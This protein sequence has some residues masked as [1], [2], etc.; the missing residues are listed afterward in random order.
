M[1]WHNEDGLYI[2]FGREEGTSTHSGGSYCYGD[3]G[4]QTAELTLDLTTL[5]E[6]ESVQ[7]DVLII[8]DNALIAEVTVETLVAAATGTGIDVGTIHISRDTSD[9]EWTADPDGLL[10]AFVAAT[11]SVVGERVTFYGPTSANT[12]ESLPASITTGGVQIGDVTTAPLLI[13]ASR[14]DSTAFTAGRVLIRV[15]YRP[16]ALTGTG[17]A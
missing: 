13:T 4:Y 14:T 3:E 17:A 1:A 5:T 16:N 6:T 15:K 2:K 7:N 10:A 11:M 9:S 8:P 12:E